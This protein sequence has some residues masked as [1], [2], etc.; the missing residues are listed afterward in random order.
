MFAVEVV[1]NRDERDGGGEIHFIAYNVARVLLIPRPTA[2]YRPRR[3]GDSQP[4]HGVQPCT[5]IP[6]LPFVL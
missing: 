2:A 4:P 3:R 6:D 1:V 5:L